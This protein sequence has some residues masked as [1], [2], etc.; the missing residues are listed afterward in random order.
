MENVPILSAESKE[1]KNDDGTQDVVIKVETL[2]IKG[3]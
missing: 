3:E 1:V 2:Q